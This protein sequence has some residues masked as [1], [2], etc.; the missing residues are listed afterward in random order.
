MKKYKEAQKDS[1]RDY[2]DS[3]ASISS[4]DE[5]QKFEDIANYQPVI[6]CTMVDCIN[7]LFD[8]GRHPENYTQVKKEYNV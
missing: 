1:D 3:V 5:E 2:H 7:I 6:L 4:D 8:D